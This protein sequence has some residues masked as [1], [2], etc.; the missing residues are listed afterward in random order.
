MGGWHLLQAVAPL[1]PEDVARYTVRGRYTGDEDGP[2]YLEESGV[3]P[4]SNT[5]TYAAMKLR[6]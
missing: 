2:G 1:S 6:I 4:D 5:E 3:Q